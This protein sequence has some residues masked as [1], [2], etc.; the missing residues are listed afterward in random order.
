MLTLIRFFA[1][2]STSVELFKVT[3]RLVKKIRELP[4]E[5][6]TPQ[7][8]QPLLLE[9]YCSTTVEAYRKLTSHEWVVLKDA[10]HYETRLGEASYDDAS[11]EFVGET[12]ARDLSGYSAGYHDPDDGVS[13]GHLVIYPRWW[14]SGN[15]LY[16]R[17]GYRGFRPASIGIRKL[18]HDGYER[19]ANLHAHDLDI[20]GRGYP[21]PLLPAAK[22]VADGIDIVIADGC[23]SANWSI[24]PMSSEERAEVLGKLDEI[25]KGGEHNDRT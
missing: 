14:P 10:C 6:K 24:D 4:E 9:Q 13:N 21:W 20:M 19:G 16:P 15:R 1:A 7:P 17:C 5:Q 3:T 2:V 12:K 8:R 11:F 22:R 25:M 18:F 23:P